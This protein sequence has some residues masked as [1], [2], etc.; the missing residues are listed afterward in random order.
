MPRVESRVRHFQ[1]A[2][3]KSYI[4]IPRGLGTGGAGGARAPPRIEDLFSKNLKNQRSSLFFIIRAP[5][6][7][8]RSWAPDNILPVSVASVNCAKSSFTQ[9]G[10]CGIFFVK[11]T[12]AN[13]QIVGC[14]RVG[15]HYIKVK[16]FSN[17]DNNVIILLYI[18]SAKNVT[19]VPPQQHSFIIICFQP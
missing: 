8:N 17:N 10:T 7:K 3:L 2:E 6:G 13:D 4:S 19:F 1:N 9:E 18:L 11:V 14:K 16:Y 12:F 5:L 15:I